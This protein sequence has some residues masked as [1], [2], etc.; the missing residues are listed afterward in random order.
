MV[1]DEP[2]APGSQDWGVESIWALRRS[3]QAPVAGLCSAI[4]ERYGVDVLLVRILA[5]VLALSGGVGVV[6]YL[7]GWLLFPRVGS[8]IAPLYK[9]VPAASRLSPRNWLAVVAVLALVVG[10]S[11]GRFFAFGFGP[12]LV[13]GAIWYFGFHRRQRALPAGEVAARRTSAAARRLGL[14]TA[15]AVALDLTGLA[16]LHFWVGGVAP[17]GALASLLLIVAVALIVAAW[18]GRPPGL[19]AGGVAL[20]LATVCVA[21]PALPRPQRYEMLNHRTLAFATLAEMPHSMNRGLA[22]LTFDL[23]ELEVTAS[24]RVTVSAG[25]GSVELTLPDRGNVRVEWALG[26]GSFSGPDG[27]R[28]GAGLSGS[29]ERVV[30]PNRPV[31][32]V[33]VSLGAGEVVLR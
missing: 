27:S 33:K 14:A 24:R 11:S 23:S 16:I 32:D 19:L 8:E 25:L 29:Y 31:L 9:A 4:A 17:A 30:D 13:V 22:D 18:I 3:A 21:A 2:V 1:P 7:G 28:A 15:G 5:V 20:A 12:A 26:A 10:A 6:L